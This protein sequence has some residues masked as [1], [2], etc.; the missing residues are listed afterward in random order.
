[1]TAGVADGFQ[2]T[3]RERE[4]AAERTAERLEGRG[5]A[6]AERDALERASW[7]A[8]IWQAEK[9]RWRAE[10]SIPDAPLSKMPPLACMVEPLPLHKN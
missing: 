8:G 5:T 7:M 9:A 2:E 4:R 3:S 6:A 10:P 1:V